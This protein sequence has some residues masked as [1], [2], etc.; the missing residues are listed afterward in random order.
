M[1]SALSLAVLVS[2]VTLLLLANPVSSAYIVDGKEYDSDYEVEAFVQV[3]AY[4]TP[5]C[6]GRPIQFS[7]I[8]KD[9]CTETDSGPI[10]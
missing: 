5:D 10:A 9:M 6:S 1:R 4:Q 3:R 2:L 8:P 7:T